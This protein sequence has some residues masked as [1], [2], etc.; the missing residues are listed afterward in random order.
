[1]TRGFSPMWCATR[2]FRLH[3]AEPRC[4]EPLKKEVLDITT[5]F[6]FCQCLSPS[7]YRVTTIS[8]PLLILYIIRKLIITV[9]TRSSTTS[10][11]DAL[12]RLDLSQ[13]NCEKV[14]G[15]RYEKEDGNAKGNYFYTHL[16]TPKTNKLWLTTVTAVSVTPWRKFYTHSHTKKLC[17][18][19]I[20]GD[21]VFGL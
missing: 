3:T 10:P 8:N 6:L 2:F 14:Y 19:S 13:V 5:D 7:L 20:T 15:L 21:S 17:W 12:D 1:M 11:L 9:L 4:D 18:N 16:T